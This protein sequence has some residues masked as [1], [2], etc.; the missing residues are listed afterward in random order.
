MLLPKTCAAC[1]DP[2][3]AVCDR[4]SIGL[5][6]PLVTDPVVGLDSLTSLYRWNDTSRALVAALKYRNAKAVVPWLAVRLAAAARGRFDRVTWLP[7]TPDRRR[8]RGFDQA[9][10]LARAVARRLDLPVVRL[11]VRDRGPGQ[12]G[13][14]AHVRS[15]A[16][17]L[18]VRRPVRGIVLVI[19][20][21]CTTGTSM[22]RAG[23][24]LAAAGADA[25]HGLTVAR[26]S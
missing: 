23:Q 3:A 4:C 19:D 15:R 13:A 20:D 25:V 11:L 17:R 5:A 22:S 8:R 18:R 14:P 2:A 12:T 6:A 7:T 1:G 10:L 24:A 26:V 21:V 16:P 9:E